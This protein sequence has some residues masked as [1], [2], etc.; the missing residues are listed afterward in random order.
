MRAVC[1]PCRGTKPS[2]MVGHGR[3]EATTGRSKNEKAFI[4]P[5]FVDFAAVSSSEYNLKFRGGRARRHALRELQGH[6]GP[7]TFE[8]VLYMTL[9]VGDAGAMGFEKRT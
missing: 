4:R 6:Q 3:L 5:R 2:R 8:T 7:E 1:E 9:P